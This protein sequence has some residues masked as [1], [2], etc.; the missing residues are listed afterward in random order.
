MLTRDTTIESG[1]R[2]YRVRSTLDDATGSSDAGY[3]F[4][5]DLMNPC[6]SA[7]L[8]APTIN[9]DAPIHASADSQ[10]RATFLDEGDSA[11]AARNKLYL[12]GERVFT[13][14]T[15]SESALV[16]WAGVTSS[17]FGHH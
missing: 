13:V 4:T 11:G 5:I 16:P 9:L 8:I 3:A 1:A 15:Q 7:S 6:N 14:L 12:C 17:G 10:A 2:S